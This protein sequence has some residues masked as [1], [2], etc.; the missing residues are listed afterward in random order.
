M[1]EVSIKAAVLE[2]YFLPDPHHIRVEAENG[3][4][5]STLPFTV[6]SDKQRF[7]GFSGRGYTVLDYDLNTNV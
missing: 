6:E 7:P 5:L 3:I 1:A 2:G 4:L